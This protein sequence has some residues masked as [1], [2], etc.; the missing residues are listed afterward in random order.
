MKSLFRHLR[1]FRRFRCFLWRE[2]YSV[3][4][5]FFSF[6]LLFFLF[7]FHAPYASDV[8]VLEYLLLFC[9]LSSFCV[10]GYSLF[11]LVFYFVLLV[12]SLSFFV[13][14]FT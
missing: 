13:W 5:K 11:Y 8:S 6:L 7:V 2:R 14:Y 3:S 12:L 9:F 10:L 1:L 4:F